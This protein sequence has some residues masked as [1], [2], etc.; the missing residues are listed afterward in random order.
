MV[1]YRIDWASQAKKDSQNI[2]SVNLKK[3]VAKIQGVVQKNPFERTP[4]HH[5]ERLKGYI[6]PIYTRMINKQHRYVYTV[7]E[8]IENAKNEDGEI[9]RGIVVVHRM[10][11]HF[12]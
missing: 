1:M 6:P 3:Q 9:Y 8:N 11:G 12:P 4:G 5:F 2:E 7:E 10:W